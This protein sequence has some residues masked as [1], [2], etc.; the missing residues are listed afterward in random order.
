MPQHA[1]PGSFLSSGFI[2]LSPLHRLIPATRPFSVLPIILNFLA[3]GTSLLDLT[4][5][6]ISLPPSSARALFNGPALF[7]AVCQTFPNMTLSF[8]RE[9]E[10]VL[11]LLNLLFLLNQNCS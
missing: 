10:L 6:V 1:L 2:A 11:N 8:S 7:Q 9:T 4:H 3:F 5:E